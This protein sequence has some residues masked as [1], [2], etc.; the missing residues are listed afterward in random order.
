MRV[1][2]ATDIGQQRN[3]NQ[4][5]VYAT[6]NRIGLLPNLLVVADGMGG[7]RGGDYASR[8]VVEGLR[9]LIK[10]SKETEP[11][12]I[13]SNAISE[14]NRK[15]WME[16]QNNEQ[17]YNMGTTL[18]AATIVDMKLYVANVGDS[19]LYVIENKTIRQ[20]TK[21]HSLVEEMVQNGELSKA[22][23]R[24]HPKKNMI[25]R[26]LGIDKKVEIDFFEAELNH[27]SKVL[28]CSDGLTNMLED[29]EILNVSDQKKELGDICS[30]LI[31]RANEEGGKDNISVVMA[32][33]ID[34]SI[35]EEV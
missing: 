23:A 2:A 4:D 18:V 9:S 24:N 34:G 28:L 7:H 6:E 35:G 11:V 26:A 20:L 13:L 30:K 31:Y 22:D 17:L 8:F 10:N 15:L 14:V 32:D 25:T 33:D 29:D 27:A 3:T 1:Y 19:R 16:A 12:K 5:Y 21:D